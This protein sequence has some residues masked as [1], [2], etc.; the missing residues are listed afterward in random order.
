MPVMESDF[1]SDR[2]WRSDYRLR[3]AAAPL[4][5]AIAASLAALDITGSTQ[6]PDGGADI[7]PLAK[8]GTSVMDLQQDGTRYFDLRHTA[9]DPLDKIDPAQ[10]A[11][12]VAAWTAVL[13]IAANAKESLR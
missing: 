1:G 6:A 13:S 3:P 10:L 4:R 9:D 8:A 11:Q 12:N 5:D 2:V 7:E